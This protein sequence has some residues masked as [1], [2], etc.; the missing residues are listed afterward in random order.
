MDKPIRMVV[1]TFGDQVLVS[2]EVF[3]L[4]VDFYLKSHPEERVFIEE[5]FQ[6]EG[7]A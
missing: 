3:K 7:T 4:F 5:V 1:K 6:Q 2:R